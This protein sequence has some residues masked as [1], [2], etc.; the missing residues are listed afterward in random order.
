[1]EIAD[2]LTYHTIGAAQ[3]NYDVTG[4]IEVDGCTAMFT[5]LA[6]QGACPAAQVGEYAFVVTETT[7]TATLIDDPCAGRV[8]GL[9][10]TVFERQP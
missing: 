5:D 8:F 4:A 2:D 6:G 3:T 7:L 10:G 1:M 9:D